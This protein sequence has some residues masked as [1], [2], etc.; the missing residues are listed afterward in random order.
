MPTAIARTNRCVRAA[1]RGA[2]RGGALVAGALGF[3]GPPAA[4]RFYT[5]GRGAGQRA[6]LQ[7][8]TA[9]EPG[10]SPGPLTAFYGAGLSGSRA[11]SGC[12]RAGGASQAR[13]YYAGR[14]G[15]GTSEFRP[16][17]MDMYRR[18]AQ[19]L[20]FLFSIPCAA[21]P[22]SSSSQNPA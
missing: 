7:A 18:M 20:M 11:L 21:V 16:S 5:G 6:D 2:E 22:L 15:T 3:G 1:A 4:L 9:E 14:S 10:V 17:L 12:A 13:H 8:P 19:G